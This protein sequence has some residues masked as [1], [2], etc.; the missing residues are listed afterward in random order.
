MKYFADDKD[1]KISKKIKEWMNNERMS[2]KL[3]S[4]ALNRR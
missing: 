2:T 1:K 3:S 4:Q